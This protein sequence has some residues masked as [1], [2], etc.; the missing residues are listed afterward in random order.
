VTQRT[1]FIDG[2]DGATGA[3]V[4]GSARGWCRMHYKRWRKHGDP[5]VTLRLRNVFAECTIDD[6]GRPHVSRG[7]C[8]R[9]YDSWKNYGDP[10]A[11]SRVFGDADTRFWAMVGSGPVPDYAPHLGE[12]WLWTG[13]PDGRGY[14]QFKLGDRSPMAHRV[15]Y[16]MLVCPIPDGLD[17]DHLCRVTMCVNPSH[18]DPV[19]REVNIQRM[20][21]ALGH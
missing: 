7:W 4:P 9:H 20:H 14:A 21:E 5:L 8:R 2:C 16:E 15:A 19:T 6:C 10:L 1:C 3:G 18:M 11:A 12:C 17:L 13:R